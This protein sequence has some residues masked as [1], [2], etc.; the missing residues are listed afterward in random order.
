MTLTGNEDH[1]ITLTEAAEMTKRFRDQLPSTGGIIAHCFG[2]EAVQSVLNQTGCVGLRLY[3]GIDAN[4]VEHL[5]GTGV[6]SSGNDLYTGS[7]IER[8]LI[9]PLECSATNPLNTTLTS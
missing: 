4:N 9:C 5:V 8:T 7:L 1:R 6:D 3:F 2:K